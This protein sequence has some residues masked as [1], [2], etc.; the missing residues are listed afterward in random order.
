MMITF[1]TTVG[2]L[3]LRKNADGTTYPIVKVGNQEYGLTP[4]ELVLWSSLAFQI[5]NI[6]DL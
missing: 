5:L 6:K 3:R 4:E 2:T 1:Y